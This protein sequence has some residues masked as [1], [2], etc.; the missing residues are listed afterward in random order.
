MLGSIFSLSFYNLSVRKSTLISSWGNPVTCAR[1]TLQIFVYSTALFPLKHT[2][3]PT[4]TFPLCS[5]V[6]DWFYLKTSL[7]G[8]EFM[9]LQTYLMFK[10]IP[11]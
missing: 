10:S 4:S 8:A 6:Q 1:D 2:S 9:P 11:T 3:V 5:G 7:R